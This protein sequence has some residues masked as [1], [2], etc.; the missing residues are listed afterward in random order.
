VVR[1]NTVI[2]F[3][4]LILVSACAGDNVAQPGTGK[5][6]VTQNESYQRVWRA[7]IAS[8]GRNFSIEHSNE[9]GGV[10]RGHAPGVEEI[11][12]FVRRSRTN[13]NEI[14]IEVAGGKKK[15]LTIT[16][17]V[18]KSP[19]AK[20]WSNI[21]FKE[22]HYELQNM[23]RMDALALAPRAS[24]LRLE[25]MS[26]EERNAA[27]TDVR[28]DIRAQI[29][30]EV[31]AQMQYEMRVQQGQTTTPAR[32]QQ[33]QPQAPTVR[34]YTSSMAPTRAPLTAPTPMPVQPQ[35]PSQYYAPTPVP[36]PI[37]TAPLP[38]T[39]LSLRERL[40]MLKKMYQDQLISKPEYEAKKADILSD[41]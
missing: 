4:F 26:P 28:I 24:S 5:K 15:G 18:Y 16:S 21:L 41:L 9:A 23:D 2:A 29:R 39:T 14:E 36:A 27:E 31:R 13:P 19:K 20:N 32:R 22:I 38:K 11:G 17:S 10:I 37:V 12:V 3:A 40:G 30:E 35:A 25:D 7:T 34:E 8:A 6:F 1:V 33:E